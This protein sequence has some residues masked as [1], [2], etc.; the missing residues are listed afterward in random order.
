M[1]WG[2]NKKKKTQNFKYNPNTVSCMPWWQQ[3]PL[4]MI[5][6]KF[7]TWSLVTPC[8][9]R[10]YHDYPGVGDRL[11]PLSVQPVMFSR[12]LSSKMGS[13]GS[14]LGRPPITQ[15]TPQLVF[16]G[17][18]CLRKCKAR[19]E[20]RQVKDGSSLEQMTFIHT[21]RR[22]CAGLEKQPGRESHSRLRK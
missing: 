1:G 18:W 21:N 13:Q 5:C 17:L 7:W 11:M 14:P 20:L 4:V 10:E 15:E 9:R 2:W 12:H 6:L 3:H 19:Q 22:R 8:E 16:A